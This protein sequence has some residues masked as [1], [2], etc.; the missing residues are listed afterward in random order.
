MSYPNQN[1]GYPTQGPPNPY[2]S[3]SAP[4][5]GAVPPQGAPGQY[6]PP[7]V[8][9]YPSAPPVNAGYPGTPPVNPAYPGAPTVSTAPGHA[10]YAP[11]GGSASAPAQVPYG[12]PTIQAPYGQPAAYSPVQQGYPAPTGPGYQQR[13]GG[14]VPPPAYPP[15]QAPYSTTPISYGM[16]FPFLDFE[17][18][19]TPQK[20]NNKNKMSIYKSIVCS[21]EASAQIRFILNVSDEKP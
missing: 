20:N 1:P 5:P 15:A 21:V 9:G 11:Y 4:Y 17:K 16:S 18:K 2:P 6:P 12:A 13:P 8:P 19:N 7:S 14:H 3:P 10:P